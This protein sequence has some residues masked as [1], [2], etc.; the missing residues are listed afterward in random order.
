MEEE[1]WIAEPARREDIF[2]VEPGELW[3]TVLRRK[4][5]EYALLATMPVDPSVN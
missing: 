4:G 5:R 3:A 1:A 2:T